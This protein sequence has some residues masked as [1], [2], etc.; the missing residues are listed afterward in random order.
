MTHFNAAHVRSD[1]PSLAWFVMVGGAYFLTAQV[2][3]TFVVEP[4]NIAA[5]WP[6]V[7]LA[8]AVLLLRPR[9]DWPFIVVAIGLAVTVANLLAGTSLP[10]SLGFAIANAVEPL[11]AASLMRTVLEPPIKMTRLS[12]VAA[13]VFLAATGSMS[14]TSLL[15]AAVATFGFGAPFWPAWRVWLV[16]GALGMLMVCPVVLTAAHADLRFFPRGGSHRSFGDLLVFVLLVASTFLIFGRVVKNDTFLLVLP[17]LTLPFLLWISVRRGPRGAALSSLAL[18]CIAVWETVRGRG[19]FVIAGS[20]KAEHILAVQVY[21]GVAVLSALVV[22][23]VMSERL[24]LEGAL[25][26]SERRFRAMFN[27]QFQFVGLMQPNGTLIEA[28]RTALEFGGL[29]PEDVLDKP[30]WHARWWT[31][32]PETQRRLREAIQVAANGEF[33]RY[34]VEVLGAGN[35]TTT[36]RFLD[37]AR[38]RRARARDA[39][40][41]RRA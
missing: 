22:A 3:L 16:G 18:S 14:V 4:E 37:Q 2:S 15:G 26:R 29:E 11:L 38:V 35:T 34:D 12:E 10:I 6:P 23:A 36:I 25:E 5:I 20:S 40:H 31:I 27:S 21:L 17:Y 33:V 9:R 30:F 28:N 32:S 13:L 41:C 8:L 24:G 1:R 39:A 7:G 19:P